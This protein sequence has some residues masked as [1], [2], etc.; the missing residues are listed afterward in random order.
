MKINFCIFSIYALF[1]SILLS[2]C[3]MFNQ[4]TIIKAE[5]FM[6]DTYVNIQIYT[7]K[8]KADTAKTALDEAMMLIKDYENL[9]SKSI[10]GSDIYNIN[11]SSGKLVEVSNETIEVLKLAIT[12]GELSEGSFDISIAPVS[13]CWNFK[14]SDSTPPNERSI[15][16][17]IHKVDYKNIIISNNQVTL[18]VPNMSID[19]GGIAKGYIADKLKKFL[20]EKGVN[21]GLINLGGNVLMIGSKPNNDNFKIGI[22]K[23]FDTQGSPISSVENSDKSVVTSGIYQRYFEYEDKLYHHI[24]D[25]K[26]GYP[27]DTDLLSAT[28]ISTSSAEGD[29]LSTICMT[30]GLDKS[31]ELL[32]KLNNI[33]GEWKNTASTMNEM[34][35][36][37]QDSEFIEA[38]FVTKDYEVVEYR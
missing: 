28:I 22:Q 27:I 29:A 5:D 11:H 14:A 33:N 24:L 18:K 8:D 25:T 16:E 4:T 21:S 6:L 19:L 13:A 3:S 10:E 2:G 32:D 35:D 36:S 23:P 7:S 17:A 1:I 9:L 31:I 30:M 12:Y 26:T 34:S 37:T 38:I 15:K 20:I